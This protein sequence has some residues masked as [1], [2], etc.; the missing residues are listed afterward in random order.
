M[1]FLFAIA[2]ERLLDFLKLLLSD[3]E[4]LL[5]KV[6]M[7]LLHVIR[8][9]YLHQILLSFIILMYLDGIQVDGQVEIDEILDI[10]PI[11]S[12]E[13]EERVVP[14]A[15]SGLP[16]ALGVLALNFD[17]LALVGEQVDLYEVLQVLVVLP[18]AEH[19][20]LVAFA[21]RDVPPADYKLPGL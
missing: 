12:R 5:L 4:N 2:V 8:G 11:E 21:E 9:Q 14:D 16:P 20:R 17:G 7:L 18:A 6:D 3:I 10:R 1:A 13:A 19:V 15:D